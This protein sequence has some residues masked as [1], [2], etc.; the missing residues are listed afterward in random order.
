MP[1]SDL[2]LGRIR[3]IG[4][5]NND[6][7]KLVHRLYQYTHWIV[8]IQ[9]YQLSQISTHEV[10]LCQIRLD[11]V[12]NIGM[13]RSDANL[14]WPMSNKYNQQ[15]LCPI[16]HCGRIIMF[17]EEILY[18]GNVCCNGPLWMCHIVMFIQ[19]NFFYQSYAFEWIFFIASYLKKCQV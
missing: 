1:C 7:V 6:Y 18:M 10:G 17:H 19:S 15:C 13:S 9:T 2:F 8:S 11:Y 3:Q 16:L 5:F 14:G 4:K 12:N